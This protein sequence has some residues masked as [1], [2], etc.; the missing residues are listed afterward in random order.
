MKALGA[1]LLPEAGII[2]DIVGRL[3]EGGSPETGPPRV[4]CVGKKKRRA[5]A[6]KFG[7]CAGDE[8]RRIDA[9]DASTCKSEPESDGERDALAQGS[10]Q[11]WADH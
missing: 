3:G 5:L 1:A 8:T 9:F 2:S 4:L 11:I 6:D 7:G 10:T